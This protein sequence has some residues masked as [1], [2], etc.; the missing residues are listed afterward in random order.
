MFIDQ[1]GHIISRWCQEMEKTRNNN[2]RWKR[3]F[4]QNKTLEW[5]ARDGEAVGDRTGSESGKSHSRQVQ[6]I[7]VP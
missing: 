2:Q 6:R 4:C 7:C 5:R 3:N 1:W